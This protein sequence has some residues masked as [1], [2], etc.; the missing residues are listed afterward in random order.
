[1]LCPLGILC[2]GGNFYIRQKMWQQW[3][4]PICVVHNKFLWKSI[5]LGS[6]NGAGERG[7][8]HATR[9]YGNSTNNVPGSFHG[10]P[11]AATG[12]YPW[13]MVVNRTPRKFSVLMKAF[14]KWDKSWQLSIRICL[15]YY[16]FYAG[17]D[18]IFPCAGM[19]STHLIRFWGNK[20][21]DA[22]IGGQQMFRESK[23]LNFSSRNL[24]FLF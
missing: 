7:R 1:M 23:E 5:L 12:F 9:V 15:R 18:K 24:F 8:G 17:I 4:C 6:T 21:G 16:L 14:K 10:E 13:N 19:H 22:H 3:I 11:I 2:F 20:R